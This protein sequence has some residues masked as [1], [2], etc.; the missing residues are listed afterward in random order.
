M[1]QQEFRQVDLLASATADLM[2]TDATTGFK[3]QLETAPMSGM[4]QMRIIATT[5]AVQFQI[6]CGPGAAVP[7]S[8]VPAGGTIGVFPSENDSAPIQFACIAG[9]AIAVQLRETAAAVASVMAVIEFV[10]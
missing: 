1:Q 2:S 9:D 7:T 6:F 5:A 8:N 3:S 10:G 4:Y